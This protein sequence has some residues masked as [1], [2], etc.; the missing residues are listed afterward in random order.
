MQ[1]R[2]G[3][4]QTIRYCIGKCQDLPFN[5]LRGY[6]K[7][8]A[9]ATHLKQIDTLRK[10][11]PK[12]FLNLNLLVVLASAAG[13]YLLGS[14]TLPD[15]QTAKATDRTIEKGYSI[16][17]KP[18]EKGNCV[19]PIQAKTLKTESIDKSDVASTNCS[20]NSGDRGF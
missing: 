2:R 13:I 19:E 3:A 6:K 1:Y 4:R 20:V 7:R 18:E 17:V 15:S 8:R 14:S 12:V 16:A 10:L 9:I 5:L 11:M